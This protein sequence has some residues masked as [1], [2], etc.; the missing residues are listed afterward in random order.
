MM[1]LS[2]WEDNCAV[3]IRN[4]LSCIRCL[5]GIL[6]IGYLLNG[7]N[8]LSRMS[9]MVDPHVRERRCSS[10]TALARDLERPIRASCLFDIV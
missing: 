4:E 10:F 9:V 3:M 5:L 8:S 1:V 2:S 6:K 7:N